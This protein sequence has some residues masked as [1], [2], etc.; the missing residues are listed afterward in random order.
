MPKHAGILAVFSELHGQTLRRIFPHLSRTERKSSK[1]LQTPTKPGRSKDSPSC[2]RRTGH[3]QAPSGQAWPLLRQMLSQ[4]SV[5]YQHLRRSVF[6]EKSSNKCCICKA[7]QSYICHTMSINHMSSE[8]SKAFHPNFTLLSV[9]NAQLPNSLPFG[10]SSE[11]ANQA[12]NNSW[13][14]PT[15]FGQ[16]LGYGAVQRA[17]GLGQWRR[18]KSWPWHKSHCSAV[19]ALLLRP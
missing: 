3:C 17:E 1:P 2:T 16:W 14:H 19:P 12:D 11:A 10:S 7:L 15:P 4:V 5:V 13:T 18:C 8:A 9:S 6:V